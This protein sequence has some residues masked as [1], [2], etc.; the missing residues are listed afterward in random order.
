[1][2]YPR[3]LLLLTLAVCGALL[4]YN[5]ARVR[6]AAADA[7]AVYLPRTPP[8]GIEQIDAPKKYSLKDALEIARQVLDR[9][10][11]EVRDY[12]GTLIKR[13]RIWGALGEEVRMAFK[14]RQPP[15]DSQGGASS[16]PSVY[17]KFESPD[18]VAG[19]EV[20]WQAERNQGKL[21]SHEAGLKRMLGRMELDPHGRLAM[22][23]QKYPITEIGLKRLV[24]KLIEKAEDVPLLNQA[25]VEIVESQSV[26]DTPCTLIQVTNPEPGGGLDFHIA[27]IFIDSERM[28]PVRYAAYL[29]PAEDGQSPPLEEEY[30]Y[31]NVK[32]NVGLSDADF[33]PEN[34][35]YDFP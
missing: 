18:S 33:D 4:L 27:Q 13:E 26:H 31:L 17:L 6:D 2:R 30:T 19:R 10:N 32:T 15:P 16:E 1:M 14:I 9:M 11:A 34:S 21:I 12:Q 3:S 8:A 24:E 7:N 29:W 35:A 20:I 22:L 28:L 25:K 23:G 5:R